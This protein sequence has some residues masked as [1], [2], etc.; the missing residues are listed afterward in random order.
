MLAGVLNEA[1]GATQCSYC[2]LNCDGVASRTSSNEPMIFLVVLKKVIF[3]GNRLHIK[4]S[5]QMCFDPGR[6]SWD[7]AVDSK[8]I[9]LAR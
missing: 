6:K 9:S 5:L 2:S 1:W 4:L 8:L 3:I 7:T